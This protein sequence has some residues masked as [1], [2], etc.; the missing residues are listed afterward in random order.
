MIKCI[1]RGRDSRLS[2]LCCFSC[3]WHL[4]ISYIFYDQMTNNIMGL[5]HHASLLRASRY[6]RNFPFFSNLTLLVPSFC[7]MCALYV[8]CREDTTP[9][10][11]DREREERA[12]ERGESERRPRGTRGARAGIRASQ[13][14]SRF[15][16]TYILDHR[17]PPPGHHI[18]RYYIT[19]NRKKPHQKAQKRY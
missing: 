2:A 16:H 15:P 17:K 4:R 18:A 9:T 3:I 1:A 13:L 14:L 8:L 7:K 12:R 6:T 11:R 10:T 5:L 19:G